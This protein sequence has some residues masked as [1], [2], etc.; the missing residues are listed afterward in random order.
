MATK[1]FSDGAVHAYFNPYETPYDAF[2][3]YMNILSDFEIRV[4]RC[5]PDTDEQVAIAKLEG[6]IKEK[7][8]IIK[9]QASEINKLGKKPARKRSGE[10]ETAP[11]ETGTSLK[12]LAA[13][14]TESALKKPS[15]RKTAAPAGRTK[16]TVRKTASKTTGKKVT[17]RK[18]ALK[19]T[20]KTGNKK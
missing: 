19:K 5:F 4:K 7:D 2:M 17:A 11:K 10:K 15:A 13:R 1:F 12:E 18:T 20:T 3:N 8:E 9:K 16:S 6:I 14:I